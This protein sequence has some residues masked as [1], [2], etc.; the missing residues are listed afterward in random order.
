[1]LVGR[2]ILHVCLQRKISGIFGTTFALYMN[3]LDTLYLYSIIFWNTSKL[4]LGTIENFSKILKNGSVSRWGIHHNIRFPTY[5]PPNCKRR[6][7]CSNWQLIVYDLT[8]LTKVEQCLSIW[9]ILKQFQKFMF[10][11]Q[12]CC[13]VFMFIFPILYFLRCAVSCVCFGY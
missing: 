10:S 3:F 5:L 1:M 2:I 4:I 9:L 13:F 6:N 12:Y 11:W 8:L 7:F